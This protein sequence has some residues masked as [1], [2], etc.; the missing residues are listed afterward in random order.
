MKI[1]CK[2]I[3][4][5]KLN[6]IKKEVENFRVKPKILILQVGDR[7]D[8]NKYVKNKINTLEGIGMGAILKR[9]SENDDSVE[10]FYSILN[11]INKG[12]L[13]EEIN[14]IILQLPL[15]DN[16]KSMTNRLVNFISKIKDIDCL[17]NSSE[18]SI[19]SGEYDILPCTVSGIMDIFTH[20]DIDVQG[21]DILVIGRSNIVGKPMA[22]TL[23]NKGATV[24]VA[25]SKTKNLSKLIQ[26]NEII[27]SAVGKI[28]LITP[29]MVNSNHIL[30][31]VGINFNGNNMV[32]DVNKGCYNI[33]KA[34][35]S[36]P[37]GV[38][39]LTTTSVAKNLLTL[40]KK[41]LNKGGNN[42]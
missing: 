29:D 16:V 18:S 1:D 25:N 13:D 20:L 7:P 41:Q 34:Y 3:R 9:I 23:I 26:N 24:T 22:M 5:K 21:K 4:D 27:I 11:E 39:L 17:G 6:Q 10:L 40:Y 15:P 42:D 8:S 28:D 33:A 30:I 19:Y 36:V 14:G 12:N 2:E 38:G 35:T 37:G 31:D 32:G